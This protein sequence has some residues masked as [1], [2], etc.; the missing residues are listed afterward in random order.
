MEYRYNNKHNDIHAAPNHFLCVVADAQ[1]NIK[2]LLSISQELFFSRKRGKKVNR[3]VFLSMNFIIV[4]ATQVN[5]FH[6][7]SGIIIV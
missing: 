3:F 6:A 5:I 2:F 1:E 7:S 4:M